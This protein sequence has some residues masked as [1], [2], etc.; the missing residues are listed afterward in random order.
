M[1]EQKNKFN[2]EYLI[3]LIMSFIPIFFVKENNNSG[4]FWFS[5]IIL[6][7]NLFHF[8]TIRYKAIK[9]SGNLI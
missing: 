2:Y 8:I 6:I 4:I 3:G 9:L 7:M 5:T 1:N